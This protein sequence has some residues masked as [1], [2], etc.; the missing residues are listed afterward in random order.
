[1]LDANPSFMMSWQ[2]L[3]PVRRN[4]DCLQSLQDSKGAG[5]RCG[6]WT[7]R[8][9]ALREAHLEGAEVTGRRMAAA[10]QGSQ[11]R[12]GQAHSGSAHSGQCSCV[13]CGADSRVQPDIGMLGLQEAGTRSLHIPLTVHSAL[14][15]RMMC[16]IYRRCTPVPKQHIARGIP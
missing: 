10:A 6:A 8:W 3:S 14:C 13:Y 16:L 11:A 1:M 15:E 2:L 12:A 7:T 4:L 9:S 5:M